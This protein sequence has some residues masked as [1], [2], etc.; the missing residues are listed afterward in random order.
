M[1]QSP[2]RQRALRVAAPIVGAALAILLIV[3]AFVQVRG[4]VQGLGAGATGTRTIDRSGPVLLQSMRDLSRYEA[5]SGTFQVIVDLQKEAGF[6]PTAVVGQRTL[7]VAIGSVNAYVDFT[8][9]GDDAL[10]VSA[11]RTAVSVRLP[12]AALDKPNLDHQRSYVYADERGIVDRVKAFF[13]QSPNDQA[14]LYQVAER[15]IGDAAGQSGLAG[16]AEA[17]T[18]TMLQGLLRSLGYEQVTVN[19]V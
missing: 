8:K 4:F 9:I 15:K 14:E 5:A 13:D 6:L 10:T 2:P 12:H 11:D 19:Y 17:N 1:I 18:V 16:R 3:F 7:F